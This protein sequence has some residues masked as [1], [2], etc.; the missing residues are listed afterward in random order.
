M[1]DTGQ[2][3]QGF[4]AAK[5]PGGTDLWLVVD[6]EPLE[7]QSFPDLFLQPVAIEEIQAE[8][9]GPHAVSS[10]ALG[11]SHGPVGLTA[12]TVGFRRIC[13]EECAV[14]ADCRGD[15]LSFDQHGLADCFQNSGR[16]LVHLRGLQEIADD[17]HEFIAAHAGNQIAGTKRLPYPGCDFRE[18]HVCGA[19]SQG[20]IQALEAVH[21][22]GQDSQ[23]LASSSSFLDG[24][25]EAFRREAP[26]GQT[27]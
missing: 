25:C 17:D 10:E 5:T 19:M 2:S 7:L 15:R 1:G 13:R 20:V 27:R 18:Y 8:A 21:V 23:H 22:D 26:I 3:N 14:E 12:E 16:N 6:S 9:E 24:E 4:E 11:A